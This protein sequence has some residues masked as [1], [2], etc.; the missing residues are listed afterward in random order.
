M[1]NTPYDLIQHI[2]T[3]NIVTCDRCSTVKEIDGERSRYSVAEYLI[4]KGWTAS[5]DEIVCGNCV[6]PQ[7]TGETGN[8]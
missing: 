4:K 5:D 8:G 7:Q 2:R 6:P 3:V 1:I